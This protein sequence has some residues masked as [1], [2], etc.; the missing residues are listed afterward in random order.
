ME[1]KM[2]GTGLVVKVKSPSL[3]LLDGHHEEVMREAVMKVLQYYGMQVGQGRAP[4]PTTV[5]ITFEV[6]E[7]DM[8]AVLEAE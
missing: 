1:P 4:I 3:C 7:Y 6:S 5:K 8:Q 2:A